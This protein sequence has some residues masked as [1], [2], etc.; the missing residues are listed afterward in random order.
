MKKSDLERRTDASTCKMMAPCFV[1]GPYEILIGRGRRCTMHWGNQRFRQMIAMELEGYAAADCKRL[2][3]SII[4]RVLADIKKHSP[5]AGFI[6][7]DVATG[8]WLSFT[9]AA[10]RV[11]IA[12]A[13]R[14][15]LDDSYKSSKHSKQVKRRMDKGPAMSFS[16]SPSFAQ[17]KVMP[18]LIKRDD[19][20]KEDE[21]KMID[22]SMDDMISV[23]SSPE[24]GKQHYLLSM[25]P[26]NMEPLPLGD[27]SM[28]QAMMGS[29]EFDAL[30][31]AFARDS[32]DMEDNPY[33]PW[34]LA[35]SSVSSICAGELV[36]TP[37]VSPLPAP[38]QTR[39]FKNSMSN[40]PAAPFGSTPFRDVRAAMTA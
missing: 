4:G 7:K 26:G 36:A 19:V 29:N 39:C 23:E 16:N 2:K 22:T 3:S 17:V 13:F 1:P 34:P 9:D 32:M 35:N 5:H 12:Q 33:E 15:V 10:S 8:R 27:V 30:F 14:D 40:G 37:P 25:L 24:S 31:R 18:P 11:A 38:K 21:F 28:P 6:K 20:D